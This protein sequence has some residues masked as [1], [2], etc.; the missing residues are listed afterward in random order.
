MVAACE[1]AWR[2]IQSHH[3]ELPDTVI[4]LGS[5]VDRGRLVKL[6]HWWGG[7]WEADGELRGEVLLAG[8]ALHLPVEDVF[9]VLLHEAAH[10]LNA[11]RGVK[12]TS[13]GGRY[14]NARFKAT[15]VEVGLDVEQQPPYGWART[16]LTPSTADRYA[17]E[18]ASLRDAIRI[19]RRLESRTAADADGTGAG[20]SR[21]GFFGRT[22]TEDVA[23]GVWM[24][25][26]D[27]DGSV[28]GVPGTGVL[29]RVRVRVRG[30]ARRRPTDSDDRAALVS[31]T[32][33]RSVPNGRSRTRIR[34]S[35]LAQIIRRA[36]DTDDGVQAV[37]RVA[38]WANQH[39]ESLDQSLPAASESEATA[40]NTLA[41]AFRRLQGHLD[42][43]DLAAGNL[44]LA[45]GDHV[46][47]RTASHGSAADVASYLRLASWARWS[48]SMP[49]AES[50][51]VDF[52][53]A[54]RYQITTDEAG[55]HLA[56]GYAMPS[57]LDALPA[58]PEQSAPSLGD[59]RTDGRGRRVG[60]AVTATL[61]TAL[62]LARSGWE[63]LPC[64]SP[65]PGGCSC[66]RPDC[67]SPGKHPRTRRGLHDADE[68]SC[69]GAFVVATMADRESRG[70][71]RCHS[72]LVVVDVDP[73]HG[74]LD[75][76][77]QLQRRG[78]DSRRPAGADRIWRVA[79]L[80]QPSG[81]HRPELGGDSAGT[82][83]GCARR[84]RVRGRSA[85]SPRERRRVPMVGIVDPSRSAGPSPGTTA[86]AGT[87]SRPT[88][89]T[90]AASIE[91]FRR[92]RLRRSTTR[93]TRSAPQRRVDGIIDSTGPRSAWA[94]SW[95][96]ACS[97]P[98]RSPIT[99]T[100]LRSGRVSAP[101]RRR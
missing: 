70:P 40:S 84:W 62:R 60:S 36:L 56:Y 54:G 64:H 32:F 5:G 46:V 39:G 23:T 10:G 67:S 86:T 75:T 82:G 27:A 99:F 80:L 63:V 19:A 51:T 96:R 91:R 35:P 68:R 92:G 72:G 94:R 30:A 15:A 77:R 7:R 95:D 57:S 66:R 25:A 53:I 101:G 58:R 9:E 38:A 88:V 11:V 61:N 6:G 43:P 48:P 78:A 33:D 44:L 20:R 18:I 29:W 71:D 97:T 3:P 55:R 98:T 89:G 47:V 52:P 26:A 90:G 79:P 100:T 42:G 50:L 14:H 12:D 24:R 21:S 17:S 31:C 49:T 59:L 13:R 74:G 87:A 73:A 81:R 45:A 83:G 28:G 93:R 34:R 69:G 76:M 1:V 65:G 16:T 2:S 37:A 41:R 22:A 4:I 85:E 8:E